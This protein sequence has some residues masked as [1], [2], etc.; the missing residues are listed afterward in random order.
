[1][2]AT[3]TIGVPPLA[4][5]GAAILMFGGWIAWEAIRTPDRNTRDAAQ[6]GRPSHLEPPVPPAEA[7]LGVV[8]VG[9]PRWLIER[10]FDS[11]AP[12]QLDPIDV[13]SG[14]P[15]LRA[16]YH[17]PLM[18]PVPHLMPNFRPHEFRPGPY[19]L[20]LEFDGS[21]PGHP[22]MHAELTPER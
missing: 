16:R 3:R 11:F 20:A 6:P 15:V 1:M 7:A 14:A 5:F 19:L 13:T 10:H 18:H 21:K 12:P 17:L 8:H 22:L 9:N 4:V 2:D